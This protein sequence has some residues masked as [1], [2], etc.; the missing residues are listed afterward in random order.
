[1]TDGSVVVA[2]ALLLMP[3]LAAAEKIDCSNTKTSKQEVSSKSIQPGDRPDRRMTQFVR[4]DQSSSRN[5]EWDGAEHKVYG[6]SD[7]VATGGTHAGYAISMLKSGEQVWSKF[8]GVHQVITKEG[9]GWERHTQG[10]FRF[11][12]GTGKYQ[13]ISGGGS[14]RGVA[15]PAGLT[16]EDVCEVQY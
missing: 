7:S 10:V 15:T 8:Q 9:G 2:M 4:T 12:G 3:Q 6:Q 5:P 14:Y 16:E 11:L 13:S 1:M